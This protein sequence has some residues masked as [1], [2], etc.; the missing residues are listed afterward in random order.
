MAKITS[1]TPASP[2][3][4][5]AAYLKVSTLIVVLATLGI[6]NPT[7]AGSLG[8]P[9]TSAPQDKWLSIEQLQTRAEALGYKVRKAKLKNACGEVYALDQNGSR[10]ELFLDLTSGEVVGRL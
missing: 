3:P 6:A 9:C 7:H 5:A 10:V 2:T 8:R 4:S 1:V